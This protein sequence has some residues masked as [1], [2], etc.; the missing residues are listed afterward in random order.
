MAFRRASSRCDTADQRTTSPAKEPT[1]R[2]LPS[3]EKAM[4]VALFLR[5]FS[6]ATG[7]GERAWASQR[8]IPSWLPEARILL[9]G[10]KARLAT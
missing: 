1:A 9:S 6:R 3:G 5:P 2:V 7:V 4:C 10:E 8:R